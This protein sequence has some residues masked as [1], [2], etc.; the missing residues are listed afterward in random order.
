MTSMGVPLIISICVY[1][2]RSISVLFYHACER[3]IKFNYSFFT[4]QNM[5]FLKPEVL[6]F[7][8]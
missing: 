1:K 3:T 8:K 2:S 4:Y 5:N 7:L 6:P